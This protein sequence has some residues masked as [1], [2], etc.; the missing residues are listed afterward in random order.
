MLPGHLL[1]G[2]EDRES[3]KASCRR[4]QLGWILKDNQGG[5]VQEIM[6]GKEHSCGPGVVH[7]KGVQFRG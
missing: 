5:A 6:E 1:F 4:W 3:G 2:S 7:S